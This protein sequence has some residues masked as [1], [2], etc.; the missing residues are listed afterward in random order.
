MK[1]SISAILSILL[2]SILSSSFLGAQP[3]D[4]KFIKQQISKH[5]E[6][7]NVA[8]TEYNG[9]LMLYGKNGWAANGCPDG[10]TDALDELNDDNEYIDDVQLTENGR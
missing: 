5:G 8:I 4:R 6:C 1:R 3:S 2:L 9:D 10:L 7:R